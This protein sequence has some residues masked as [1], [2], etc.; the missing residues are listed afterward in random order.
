MAIDL[1]VRVEE[2]ASITRE[3][4]VFSPTETMFNL[5]LPRETQYEGPLQAWMK[6]EMPTRRSLSSILATRLV[7]AIRPCKTSRQGISPVNRLNETSCFG[8]RIK[9]CLQKTEINVVIFSA[10]AIDS[11]LKKPNWV[12]ITTFNWFYNRTITS[13]SHVGSDE[14][15]TSVLS[16]PLVSVFSWLSYNPNCSNEGEAC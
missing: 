10:H 3:S 15:A 6:V 13:S 9:Y 2:F 14:T 4:V 8:L 12:S 16:E 5:S 7:G 11:V 1:I